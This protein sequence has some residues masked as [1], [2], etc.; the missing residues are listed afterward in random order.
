MVL[1]LLRTLEKVPQSL[2]TVVA[3]IWGKFLKPFSSIYEPLFNLLSC[4]FMFQK[5]KVLQV[6][7]NRR[8]LGRCPSLYDAWK[9]FEHI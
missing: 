2:Y 8:F 5:K 1:G 7:R 3:R 6:S 4:L 9:A